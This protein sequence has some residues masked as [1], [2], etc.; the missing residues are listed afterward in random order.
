VLI[1][2]GEGDKKVPHWMARKLN[3]VFPNSTLLVLGTD[4]HENIYE[5]FTDEIWEKIA[6]F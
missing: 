2:S 3:E 6:G 1:V 4:K 5:D